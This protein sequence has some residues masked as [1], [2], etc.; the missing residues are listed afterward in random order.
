MIRLA[1]PM[2]GADRCKELCLPGGRI[3][4]RPL[5]G[6]IVEPNRR[7]LTKTIAAHFVQIQSTMDR[8][9]NRLYNFGII[10]ADDQPVGDRMRHFN[11]S[12]RHEIKDAKHGTV[13]TVLFSDGETFSELSRC[14]FQL[15]DMSGELWVLRRDA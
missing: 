10:V 15:V 14:G 12:N 7:I 6:A 4:A 8:R 13:A 3:G 9:A 2:A 5:R 11:L 1:A